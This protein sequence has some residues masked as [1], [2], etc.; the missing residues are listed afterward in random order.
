ME[1]IKVYNE[2]LIETNI[3]DKN[4]TRTSS[5]MDQPNEKKKKRQRAECYI[6]D[7]KKRTDCRNKRR[8]GILSS[9]KK[10]KLCTGDETYIEFIRTG[11]K[12]GDSFTVKYSTSNTIMRL[13]EDSVSRRENTSMV[14]YFGEESPPSSEVPFH[15]SSP[16][17]ELPTPSQLETVSPSKASAVPIQEEDQNCCKI[18]FIKHQSQRDIDLS[19]PWI[20]C[21]DE[22][23]T[24][25]AH[26]VCLGFHCKAYEV[27]CQLFVPRT[28]ANHLNSRILTMLDFYH[29]MIFRTF[30]PVHW[31]GV[32]I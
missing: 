5:D 25:W 6:Q 1:N 28:Q 31:A 16:E 7:A 4:A 23:C 8:K 22:E 14:S 30:L 19:S 32:S 26:I 17:P 9:L 20:G 21:S 18:C 29:I 10:L 2:N 27:Y 12:T 15:S 3:K 13:K 24:F 11:V